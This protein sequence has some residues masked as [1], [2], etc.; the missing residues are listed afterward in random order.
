MNFWTFAFICLIVFVMIG[1]YIGH[2][3]KPN[4]EARELYEKTQ[5]EAAD[6][7]Q[8][9][10]EQG[11]EKNRQAVFRQDAVGA[12]ERILSGRL[13]EEFN[14]SFDP[15]AGRDTH[16]FQRAYP[17]V[18]KFLELFKHHEFRTEDVLSLKLKVGRQQKVIDAQAQQIGI[19]L[20]N[21]KDIF[22][23]LQMGQ[24]LEFSEPT[25]E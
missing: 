9:E 17:E 20:Q 3:R 14:V 16:R 1:M 19:L 8:R 11:R 4:K 22:K 6:R 12:L 21:Q 24:P 10:E 23:A 2:N 5:R 25:Q 18:H 15:Y 13:S 7:K